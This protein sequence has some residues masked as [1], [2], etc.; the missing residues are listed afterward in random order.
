MAKVIY[1]DNENIYCM[2]VD[3]NN[4]INTSACFPIA[5]EQK[6]YNIESLVQLDKYAII[7]DIANPNGVFEELRFNFGKYKSGMILPR[8]LVNTIKCIALSNDICSYL[9]LEVPSADDDAVDTVDVVKRINSISSKQSLY[10]KQIRKAWEWCP[11]VPNLS[12]KLGAHNWFIADYKLYLYLFKNT[13]KN[14]RNIFQE[15]WYITCDYRYNNNNNNNNTIG[16]SIGI[17]KYYYDEP[18]NTFKYSTELSQGSD[19]RT[20]DT[21]QLFIVLKK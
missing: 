8:A 9:N 20:F 21:N 5:M 4:E 14:S 3:T 11:R 2:S 17:Y 16:S 12:P 6:Q 18:H 1:I 19:S 13:P 15:Q 10:M 7:T